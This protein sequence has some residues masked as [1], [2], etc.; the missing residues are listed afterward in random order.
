MY[1]TRQYHISKKNKLYHYCQDVCRSSAVLYNRANFVLRQY[2]SAVRAFDEM[3]PLYENPLNVYREVKNVLSGTKHA[4]KGAWLNYYALDHFL[5]ATK[6][7]AYYAMPSQANQ[8]TL[9]L[10]MRD[11]KSFFEATKVYKSD[12]SNFTGRP[13]MPK[14]VK[15]RM[16][17]TVVLTN[18]ICSIKDGHLL[19]FP[20]TVH[21][22]ELGEISMF[23]SLKEVRIKPHGRSFVMDVVFSVSDAGIDIKDDRTILS[24][25]ARKDNVDDMRILAIDPG[26]DNIAAVV[27]NFGANPSVIK[28]G[29]LKAA[30]QFYN[31][32]MARLS[33]AAMLCNG[34]YRTARMDAITGKRNRYIKDQ[35][36]K[37]SRH[38]ADYA[39]DNDVN[40]VIMGH[41]KM[42]KSGVDI[43]HVNN[44]NFVQL[45]IAALADMLR[46]KLAEYGI[47]FVLAEE[48]YTSKADFLAGDCI[49]TYG[50]ETDLNQFSGKRIKRGL[51]KHYDGT[52]TNADINGAGNI[53]RKVFPKVAQWD[54]GIVDMPCLVGCNVHTISSCCSAA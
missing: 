27:N 35:L 13:H 3:I 5:K 36:H 29:V 44:Q 46:Y 2:S 42:Q 14:Y 18:Q 11:Y 1:R 26:T 51:Y 32:E 17:K 50:K 6:D 47:R 24:E 30:N 16:L 25:L 52:V 28:G 31:K 23:Q 37:I 49:P 4:P 21:R 34:R 43:G 15:G 48:S 38:I 12:K 20:G 40:L 54:R 53:L 41:N 22:L 9:K 33:K 7:P 19:K 10:L 45:P 8:Q 39:R